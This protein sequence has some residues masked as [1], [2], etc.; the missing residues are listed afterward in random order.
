MRAIRHV[1]GAL[2][3]GRELQNATGVQWAAL[4]VTVI[5]MLLIAGSGYALSR[6]WIGQAVPPE[7]I[8]EISSMLVSL[9][10]G[11]LGLAQA[12]TS[13]RVGLPD[14]KRA[15]RMRDERLQADTDPSGGDQ[16]TDSPFLDP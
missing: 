13:E 7:Q 1:L 10:L 5:A 12:S 14:R 4:A 15:K 8:Y 16:R 2:K 6:G 3:A 9:L 11:A